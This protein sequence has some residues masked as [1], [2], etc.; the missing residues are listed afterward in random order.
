MSSHEKIKCLIDDFYEYWEGKLVAIKS[1][2]DTQYRFR[3]EKTMLRHFFV[4]LIDKGLI[5]RKKLMD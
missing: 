1:I 4:W 3:Y 5:N 2:K